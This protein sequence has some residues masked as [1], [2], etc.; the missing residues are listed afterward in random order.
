MA[1]QLT[2]AAA[3]HAT[4]ATADAIDAA[5]PY[6][7]P[8]AADGDHD[9]LCDDSEEELGTNPSNPDTDDDGWPDV[10]EAIIDTDPRDPTHRRAIRSAI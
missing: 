9:Y 2:A 3:C 10:I 6:I 5:V 1:L 7:T 8:A 4:D